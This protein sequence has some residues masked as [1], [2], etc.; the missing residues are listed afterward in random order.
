MS[1]GLSKKFYLIENQSMTPS[2]VVHRTFLKS[3]N[4]I[5]HF[6]ASQTCRVLPPRA[7]L[8][9][10]GKCLIC[11]QINF[12]EKF[13]RAE[14]FYCF[15]SYLLWT[16][17][18]FKAMPCCKR[19]ISAWILKSVIVWFIFYFKGNFELSN[20]I[21]INVVQLQ[22]ASCFQNFKLEKIFFGIIL[23]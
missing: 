15:Q 1:P 9:E 5:L 17:C 6:R 8:G 16:F 23:L 12:I 4:S 20:N 21:W 18:F 22:K 10:L 7:E 2:Q 11:S 3:I 14:S 19:I 13:F